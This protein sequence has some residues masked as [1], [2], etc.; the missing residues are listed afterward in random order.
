[1]SRVIRM[2][3]GSIEPNL[4]HVVDRDRLETLCLSIRIEGQRNPVLVHFTGRSFRIIDGEKRWRACRKL[5]HRTILAEL[6]EEIREY[7]R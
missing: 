7:F 3:I 1:M 2:K 5:G 4:R 6:E